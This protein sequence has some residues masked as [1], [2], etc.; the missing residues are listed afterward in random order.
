MLDWNLMS[1][2]QKFVFLDNFI[3]L[4]KDN[5][6]QAAFFNSFKYLAAIVVL[7]VIAGFIIGLLVYNLPNKIKGFISVLFFIPY[8][9]SG[10]ATA[11]VVRYLLSY[12]SV[13]NNLLREEFNIDINW[14]QNPNWSF[15]VMVLLVVWKMGGYY[16]LFILSG[17][18]SIT[19]DI[20]EAS[21]LDGSVGIHRLFHIVIPTIIPTITTVVVLASGLAYG[22]FTEPY[23]LTGGGP[24]TA[25][26][27][28]QLEIYN[29]SFV[30]FNSGYGAAMALASAVQIFVTLRIV[31]FI[32]NKINKKYGA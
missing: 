14:F 8:L 2:N 11:V 16:S 27:T 7:T 15:W 13:L 30:K 5:R 25:T 32:M 21:E 10:V 29:Q 18:E 22:I 23:L 24:G 20:F 31:N 3:A 6:V 9:T 26:T 4:F 1:K 17:L 19:E 12:N 28:W